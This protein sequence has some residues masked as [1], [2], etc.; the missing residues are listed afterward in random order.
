M[1]ATPV[2]RMDRVI[3]ELGF[4]RSIRKRLKGVEL[5]LDP[6]NL[7]SHRPLLRPESM[8]L[9]ACEHD[10]FAPL[11]TIEELWLA[12][13]KPVIWRTR[14]GHISA[15]M[16]A[17]VMERTVKW[18]AERANAKMGRSFLVRKFCCLR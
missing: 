12:W 5:R 7:I 8:L 10:L 13:N 4:C 9:V 2:S 15:L 16:S 1:L 14:Q 18:L 3:E 17:P 11:E 6:L